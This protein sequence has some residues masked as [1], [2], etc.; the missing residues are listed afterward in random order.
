MATA[1]ITLPKLRPKPRT[2]IKRPS[3]QAVTGQATIPAFYTVKRIDN[4][5]LRRE[6][7]PEHRRECY[8]VPGL[9]VIV[10]VFVFCFLCLFS[11]FF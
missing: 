8:A 7:N 11:T 5:R 3:S 4:S 6:V 1:T 10:F 2:K 9:S